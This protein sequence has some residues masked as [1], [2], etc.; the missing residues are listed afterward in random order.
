MIK[1]IPGQFS[2]IYPIVRQQCHRPRLCGAS[3]RGFR[4]DHTG[5]IQR[6]EIWACSR[7]T[8]C[9]PQTNDSWSIGTS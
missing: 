8:S 4:S 3:E 1:F 2:Y 6:Y 5:V 7:I 9:T